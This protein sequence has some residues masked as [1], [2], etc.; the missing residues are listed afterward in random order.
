MESLGGCAQCTESLAR[1]M[2]GRD[3]NRGAMQNADPGETWRGSCLRGEIT[4][5][6]PKNTSTTQHTHTCTHTKDTQAFTS[7]CIEKG[8]R[9]DLLCG[10]IHLTR[11]HSTRQRCPSFSL[12]LYCLFGQQEVK[13][14]ASRWQSRYDLTFWPLGALVFSTVPDKWTAA[15]L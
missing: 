10:E 6:K 1:K 9:V 7:M 5:A 3:A 12:P 4:G 13:A 11:H 14:Q 8:W 2:W 15:L